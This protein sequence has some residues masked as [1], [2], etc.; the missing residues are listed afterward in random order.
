MFAFRLLGLFN[1]KFKLITIQF[2]PT[3]H[4]SSPLSHRSLF[5]ISVLNPKTCSKS[6]TGKSYK[7]YSISIYFNRS[8]DRIFLIISGIYTNHACFTSFSPRY[9]SSRPCVDKTLKTDIIN[10]QVAIEIFP[11]IH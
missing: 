4:G 1:L 8:V 10:F 11:L 2:E 9:F 6:F 5:R 3:R 7:R